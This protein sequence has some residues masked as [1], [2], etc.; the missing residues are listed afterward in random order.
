MWVMEAMVPDLRNSVIL[1]S[2]QEVNMTVVSPPKPASWVLKVL[3]AVTGA[4]WAAFVLIHL[5]G[6]LKVF[7]GPDSFNGYAH[8]LKNAFYPLFPKEGVL[9]MLRI[10]LIIAL[11]IHVYAA[12]TLYLRGRKARGRF[13]AK[14]KARR[15]GFQSFSAGLMPV[16]GVLILAFIILHVLDLT[17]GAQPVAPEGFAMHTAGESF[18]YS[19]LVAS[20]SRLPVAIGYVVM[21]VLIAIHI[22]HGTTT[23][24]QDLGAMGKRLRKTMAV[25]GGL[26]AAAIVLGNAAIPI[27]V[28][29][30]WIS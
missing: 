30:G 5:Y 9:W 27:A 29:V 26:A 11:A 4:I 7:L 22:A 2:S 19:N 8:W 28:Q 12:T 20:F 25:I 14:A 1:P 15:T 3:M 18:A 24:A 23:L 10:V 21:M 17:V 13:R 6:N 16:T